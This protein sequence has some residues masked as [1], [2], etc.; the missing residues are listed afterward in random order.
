MFA[1]RWFVLF[2]PLL[3]F[4]CGAWLRRP[5]R[6]TS[7]A[8]AGVLLAFSSAVSLIGATGAL[9]RD[10]FDRYTALGAAENLFGP[11]HSVVGEPIL[12]RQ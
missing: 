6:R 1:T 5:H 4:W 8:M 11:A 2:L 12:A 10:G 7:W 9:P 3:L